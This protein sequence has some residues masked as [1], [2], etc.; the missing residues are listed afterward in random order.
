MKLYR[1]V[2]GQKNGDGARTA[3]RPL[4]ILSEIDSY[5]R[6]AVIYNLEHAAAAKKS[7]P[8]GSEFSPF[9]LAR[10]ASGFPRA[11]AVFTHYGPALPRRL[12]VQLPFVNISFGHRLRFGK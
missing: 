11:L 3:N 9:L 4:V 1:I 8:Y 12:P 10:W 5:K 6:S 2:G 7:S